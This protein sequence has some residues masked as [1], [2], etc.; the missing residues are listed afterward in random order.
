MKKKILSLLLATVLILSSIPFS[1][2]N[3]VSDT[4]YTEP[5]IFVEKTYAA[6]GTSVDVNLY[7]VNNPGVAGARITVSYN[8]KLTLTGASSGETFADLDYTNP[9]KFV[10]PCNFNWDSENAEVTEDGILLTLTFDVSSDAEAYEELNVDISYTYGDIYNRDLDSLDFDV[11][12]GIISVINFIP[13]DVNDDGTVNGK[14]VTLVRRF[15]A[16]G[17]DI[18]INE[19]A[20][21][22]NDDGTVNGKDVTILRRYIAGGYDVKPIPPTPRCNHAM[23]ATAAKAETC[24]EDGNIAYWY[25]SKCEKYFSD[26]EGTE[27]VTLEETVVKTTGHTAV[28]DEAVAPTYKTTGLTEGSHCSICGVVIKAQEII[29][30]L[31]G[32]SITYNVANGDTYIASL[33]IENPNAELY[34]SYTPEDETIV[35]K[36]L[37]SPAGYKFLGWY[38]GEGDNAT[39]ITQIPKGS[40]RAWELYAHWQKEEYTVSFAS[41]MVPVESIKYTT[42]KK[43]ALPTPKL[44]KYLFVGWTDDE[45]NVWTEIPIG[46]SGDMTLYANWASYRN[47]A[48]AVKELDDPIIVE[49]SENGLMLFT[50]EIGTIENVPLFTILNLQCVNG[51][52]TEHSRTE[53]VSISEETAKTI[54][55]TVSNATTNSASWSLSKDWNNTTEISEKHLDSTQHTKEEAESLSRN[56]SQSYNVGTSYGGSNMY[57]DTASGSYK[58]SQNQSHSDTTTTETG[59]DFALSVDA[60]YSSEKSAGLELGIPI[61]DIDVGI[62]ASKKTSF[63]IGGG[64]D[65]SN[66]VKNTTTGTDSWSTDVEMGIENSNSKTDE[67]NWN[68]SV[69]YSS[70]NETSISQSVSNSVSKLISQE[71]GY[72]KSYSEGGSN[73]ES[74]ELASTDSK[75]DEFSSTVTYHTSEIVT[76][77]TSFSSTGNTYGDYRLIMAGK[78]HVFAIV[79]YD[80]AK[81]SYFV[82]TYNVLDDETEEYLDY[83]FDGTFNDYETSVV[84]FEIPAFVNDY[85]NN[86]IAITDGLRVDPDTGIIDKYT[87]VSAEEPATVIS[88]PSYVAMETGDSTGFKS[89]K[90]TGISSD[91]FRGNTDVVG[92]VL[93]HHITEIPDNAFEGCTSLKYVIC[94]GVTKIGNNAFS[95]C[96]SLNKFTIPTEINSIGTNAFTGE[97]EINA[98][99]SSA[100]VAQKVAASGANKIVL[101]ISEIPSDK[102]ENLSLE[103]GNVTYFEVQGKDK[104][105]K[106]LSLKSDAATTVINGVKIVDGTGISIETSSD[107]LTLNRV[108]VDSSGY[109]LLL[110]NDNT[111]VTLNGNINLSSES[112]NTVVCKNIVLSPLSV[113]VVGKMNVTDKMLICGSIEGEEYL[114]CD[115]IVYIDEETY[116][117][118]EKGL[119]TVLFDANGGSVSVE[120]VLAYFGTPIGDLPTPTRT[121]FTFNGWYTA[122]SGG[123]KITETSTLSSVSDITLYAQW[124]AKSYTVSWSTGTG[125]T[126]IVKRTSSPYA[127][128]STGTLSNGAKVYYGDILSITYT[129]AT[130]YSLATK[131]AT[132]VTVTGNVTSSTIYASANANKYTYNIVYKSSNGTSLG[133][134]TAE[135]YYGQTYTLSAPSKTG[136]NTPASQSVVW[137][138]TSSKT[139]TF[140]YTPKSVSATTKSGNINGTPSMTYNAKIEYKDRTANSVKVRLVF[141]QT[142]LAGGYTPYKYYVK[143]TSGGSS[144]QVNV[145]PFNTWQSASSSNRTCSASTDWITV[146]GLSPSTQSVSVNVYMWQANYYDSN[147]GSGLDTTFNASIPVY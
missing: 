77:T 19:D 108:T 28:I 75:S 120:S 76:T 12:G 83:S 5:T 99:A 98:T 4:D 70:S 53:E 85:V 46:T 118:Y 109:A 65:Y 94:P 69:G 29:P 140:T 126:I 37:Q 138:S 71:Y 86:R 14:D 20:A 45:K 33:A 47:K 24:T 102:A 36:N 10:S 18:S 146:S 119:I 129:A 49:D 114:T 27:E 13:G 106:N 22:V 81:K 147:M 128:V 43:T 133:S 123:E 61:E 132:S 139:V 39:K 135:G 142:I 44:D 7:L 41:D 63:E 84:P 54:A 9:G 62:S 103:V 32:Y 80:V 64:V 2:V 124:T 17:Y 92:V 50:Y 89:V 3:A 144:K 26:E 95:G 38:D 125:Y 74:Q 25:C 116:S 97:P 30:V 57:T 66:Y 141:E 105:Y 143:L 67:K 60:K 35:L 112:G 91:L 100:L 78:I 88:V 137:D 127:G 15:N 93:G 145:V 82:Y 73:S 136:Y 56:S 117:Q 40:A 96:T 87:P 34:S 90:V 58:F 1:V 51:I 104:E 59:Q 42:D 16:G 121:G 23:T 131:G 111:N 68:T 55:Q 31:E 21:N 110:T 115:N 8:S 48:T 101:D 6:A 107:N 72:G 113:S 11:D 79:G 52:V 122:A 134:S 130:G